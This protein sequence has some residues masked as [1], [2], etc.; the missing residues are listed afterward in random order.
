MRNVSPNNKGSLISS[1]LVGLGLFSASL[2]YAFRVRIPPV[3]PLWLGT[4]RWWTPIN[5]WISIPEPTRHSK[6]E[7]TDLIPEN[8]WSMAIAKIARHEY[9]PVFASETSEQLIELP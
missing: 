6:P 7:K 3:D 5:P 8:S 2:S 4:E 1:L 9:I